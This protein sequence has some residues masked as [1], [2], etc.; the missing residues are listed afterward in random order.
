MVTDIIIALISAL[1]L[2]LISTVSGVAKR[3][4]I[5]INC[6]TILIIHIITGFQNIIN[7]DLAV[8]ILFTILFDMIIEFILNKLE[9]YMMGE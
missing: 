3:F 6:L 5:F 9:T 1:L 2:E 4:I 8:W 7:L